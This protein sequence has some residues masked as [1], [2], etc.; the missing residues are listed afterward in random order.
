MGSNLPELSL[1]DRRNAPW[2]QQHPE[3]EVACSK[4]EWY[5]NRDNSD[6]ESACPSCGSEKIDKI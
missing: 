6:M 1:I 2:N 5:G 4:C 3:P